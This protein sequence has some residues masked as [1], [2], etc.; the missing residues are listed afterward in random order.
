[1]R[2]RV[3]RTTGLPVPVITIAEAVGSDVT[4][5]VRSCVAENR[6]G[7]AAQVLS[8]YL[9]QRRARSRCRSTPGELIISSA[10][11]IDARHGTRFAA[12]CRRAGG[13]LLPRD[14]H[15]GLPRP[16]S[17]RD[18]PS[19]LAAAGWSAGGYV[20]FLSRLAH[21]KGVDDLIDGFAASAGCRDLRLVIAGNG[22]QAEFLHEVAAAS[23]AADRIVFFDD[24]DD[25]EKP[26]LM[27]GL[28]GVRA[29]QQAAAGVHRDLRHRPGGEDAGRRRSGDHHRHRRDRRGGR[30][31]GADR[32]GRQ[33]R[34]RSPRPWTWRCT[35]PTAERADM[36]AAGPG[37]RAAVR[38]DARVRLQPARSGRTSASHPRLG[39]FTGHSAAVWPCGEH[40]GTGDRRFPALPGRQSVSRPAAAAAARDAAAGP[41]HWSP[42]C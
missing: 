23:P 41:C 37:A 8:A 10:D 18:R 25:D 32:S 26:Y 6:F 16:G 24:V 22:P 7:A 21:A 19:V 4:N 20:L 17:R 12:Q 38:P 27:A 3:A 5:V 33:P 14:Q 1:M 40:A 35:M 13:D 28:R 11:E 36:A 42:S 15:R 30:R 34:T 9:E 31:H 29:A 39:G 2:V